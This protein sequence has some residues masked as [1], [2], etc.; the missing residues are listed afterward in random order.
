M[1]DEVKKPLFRYKCGSCDLWHEGSPSF[2]Y[3]SPYHYDILS[4]ADKKQFARIDDDFCVIDH[5]EGTQPDYFVRCTVEIPIHGYAEGFLWGVWVSLSADNYKH[6]EDMLDGAFAP[7]TS[8]FGWFCNKLEGYPDTLLLKC[9]VH[10]Q[11]DHRPKLILEETD[12]PLSVHF[13]HAMTPEQAVALAEMLLH[14]K[15]Q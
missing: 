11:Q 2:A 13:H 5:P 4:A 3:D 15:S 10:P 14:G 12:H 1:G 8:Y 9:K 7:D 6:Y